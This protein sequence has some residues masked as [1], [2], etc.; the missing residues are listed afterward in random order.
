VAT[1]VLDSNGGFASAGA[2]R[3]H[4]DAFLQVQQSGDSLP[5]VL[6]WEDEIWSAVN[7]GAIEANT[8]LRDVLQRVAAAN[9]PRTVSP[10]ADCSG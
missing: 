6:Q 2:V 8:S 7:I 10:D 1:V 3:R 5:D 4:Y 9:P